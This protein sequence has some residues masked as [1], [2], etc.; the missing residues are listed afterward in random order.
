MLSIAE[1][2]PDVAGGKKMLQRLAVVCCAALVTV[3]CGQTDAGITTAVKSK[4]AADDTVK[5]YQID[6]TTENKVVT[7]AGNVETAA[8]KEQAVLLARNTDGVSNVVDRLVVGEAAGTA[9]VREPDDVDDDTKLDEQAAAKAREGQAKAGQ[10]ADRAGAVATDAAITT[11][12]KSKLLADPAVG[13][14][15]I[16]VDT[17]AGVVTLTGTVASRSEADQA[18]KVARGTDGVDRVVDNLKV[19]R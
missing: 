8:A 16:D 17:K 13:G 6:V 12:V 7:L 4:F 18:I 19:G 14:L 1:A 11:A 10:A 2:T 15:R 5:A 9:G 3:S